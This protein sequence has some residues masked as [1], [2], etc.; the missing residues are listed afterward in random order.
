VI[1]PRL[2]TA[3]YANKT[4]VAHPAAKVQTSLGAPK[5]PLPYHLHQLLELAPAAWM[6]HLE[7]A[8]F[9]IA[10]TRKVARLGVDHVQAQLSE[11]AN[12][13]GAVLLCYEDIRKPDVW[14]HRRILSA[15]LEERTGQ[16]VD[17]M[18]EA[19]A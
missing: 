6:L 10:Y 5:F 4:L 11:V 9:S 3:R 12:D 1:R 7:E 14:C 16:A 13:A 8:E 19:P 18:P 15:W 17:E 2:F